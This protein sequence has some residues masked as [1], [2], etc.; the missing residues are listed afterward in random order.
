MEALGST[1]DIEIAR[2]A[3]DGLSQRQKAI[4]AN[5]A[6]VMTPNYQRKEI[7]FEDQLQNMIQ[8][9][10]TKEDIKLANSRAM[11]YNAS[12]LDEIRRPSQNQLSMLNR[13]SFNGYQPEVVSDMS[14]G[15][16][17]TGNNVN[18]EHEMM[19][20]AK[21]GTQYSI[22]AQLESKMLGRIADVIKGG[23]V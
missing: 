4:A 13:S 10:N 5:T 3:L 23:G 6:N 1:R 8:Q 12:S 7:A 15:D 22:L 21:A 19:D 18:I 14:E 11:T 2:L 17:Q 20:M 9:E 16:P